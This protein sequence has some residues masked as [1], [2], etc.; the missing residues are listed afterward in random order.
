MPRRS[1]AVL[2]L[3]LAA[4]APAAPADK[5]PLSGLTPAK[6]RPGECVYAY[7]VSTSVPEC[8]AFVNQGLGAYYSY[9][10]ME[11]ARDF[12][13]AA[14]LDPDCAFAW[15]G[16]SRSLEKWGKGDHSAA[17]QKA[18]AVMAGAS[19]PERLLITAR[20]QEK[21]MLPGIAPDQR[22]IVSSKTL[23]EL[24]TIYDDDQEGWFARGQLA[25]GTAA[26]PYYKA[27]VRINPLH[28][29]ATHELVH[30]YENVR[31][32][33][34]GWP[35]AEAYIA[36]TPGLA[37]PFHMQA[38]LAT[39]LGKWDKTSDRSAQAVEL[40]RAYH[41]EVGVKPK[42]DHQYSHHLEILTVSLT[43]DG[44]FEEA[45]RVKGWAKEAGFKHWVPW[46]RLAAASGDAAGCREA[47]DH[48]RKREKG[49]AAYLAALVA[50]Q[51][52][53]TERAT[54]EV[55]TL[56]QARQE[57]RDDRTLE[58]R[59][60]EAQGLLLCRT[61]AAAEGVKLL[62][63]TAERTKN[64]F[65]HHA[66]GNGAVLMEVW[67]LAALSAGL[68]A[69]AEEGLLEALAHDPGSVRAALGMEALCERTGRS[70]EAARYAALA[71]KGWSRADAGRL[72]A[73]REQVRRP[74]QGP[75]APAGNRADVSG[76]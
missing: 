30:Q 9:V 25:G 33:A 51:A 53:D 17:L 12:E 26:V 37:H 28:P 74:G 55:E 59:L 49:T 21:G 5:L 11:A 18:Q 54:A 34:L 42:D 22:K 71:S 38:H 57:K 65:A 64:D 48:F 63:R 61:G 66:W 10:W 39:R 27:L 2:A 24:L 60:G 40:E 1:A 6:P 75:S 14:R 20:L 73:L 58:D 3:L 35:Y 13:T 43:H 70:Q 15:Y 67:G 7:A 19:H 46:F 8:Q 32:P 36:S 50:L 56:R 72:A 68:D 69:E 23:D 31:R 76:R 16:L 41:R 29:G 62:R 4:A 47:I 44:R 52:G 45:A